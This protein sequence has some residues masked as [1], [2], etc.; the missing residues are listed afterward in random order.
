MT[1]NDYLKLFFTASHATGYQKTGDDAAIIPQSNIVSTDQFI[2]GTHFLW[3]HMEAEK[4]GYKAIVQALSDLAAMAALPTAILCS[5][6]WHNKDHSH[7]TPFIE[8]I[9]QACTDYQVPLVGG[10]ISRTNNHFYADI[11]ALGKATNPIEK[12]GAGLG[13]WITLSGP[14]GSARAG[15]WATEHKLHYPALLEAY[16]HPKAL[17]ELALRLSQK[18]WLTSLTD[19]S[20][21][22]S[23]SLLS[24]AHASRQKFVIEENK[25]PIHAELGEF[26]TNENFSLKDYKLHSGEDYQLLMT[27]KNSISLQEIQDQG[28]TVIGLVSEGQN[29]FLKTT[30]GLEALTEVGWDPFVL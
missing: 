3:N 5:L 19:I 23:K 13:D 15:L 1:E 21:S 4:I 17:I 24:L 25:I 28:L 16:Q 18:N 30:N 27:I 14:V 12:S 26:C 29:V 9:K 2:E 20:D 6:A 7:I 10:D 11:V 22:L 8:G